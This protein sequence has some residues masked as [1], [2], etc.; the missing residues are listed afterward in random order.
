MPHDTRAFEVL[1]ARGTREAKGLSVHEGLQALQR[2]SADLLGS[3]LR[4][5]NHLFLRERVDALARLRGGLLHDLQ[6]E[7]A[8][9]R[10]QAT[11]T[12]A[13][14]DLAVERLEHRG[15]LLAGQLG[16]LADLSHD[17]RLRRCATFLC[18]YSTPRKKK[19]S[20]RNVP[21]RAIRRAT[22]HTHSHS[23]AFSLHTNA[24]NALFSRPARTCVQLHT[25][26][27]SDFF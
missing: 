11:A 9:Q 13:L 27:T 23:Q 1:R 6:L 10:E 8:G 17:F 7:Q 19:C 4:L 21:R 5:E 3:R 2:Q 26:V 16:V 12:Q 24:A 15:N 14:L 20:G 25:I 18:H 22:Y